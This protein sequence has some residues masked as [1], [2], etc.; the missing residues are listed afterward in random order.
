MRIQSIVL[1][2][3]ASNS[4]INNNYVLSFHD[5]SDKRYKH[6]ILDYENNSLNIPRIVRG[7]FK[8]VTIRSNI[9]TEPNPFEVDDHEMCDIYFNGW[10]LVHYNAAKVKLH[11]NTIPNLLKRQWKHIKTTKAVLVWRVSNY[12]SNLFFAN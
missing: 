2:N 4:S 1:H 3:F 7:H 9:F 11:D 5:F 12:F 10:P 6:V 8:T